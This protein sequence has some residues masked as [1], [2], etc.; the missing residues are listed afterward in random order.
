MG[1]R[2][3]QVAC[4]VVLALLLGGLVWHGLA[5]ADVAIKQNYLAFADDHGGAGMEQAA[6]WL[7]NKAPGQLV[8]ADAGPYFEWLYYP[9]DVL[10]MRA[11]P[12]DL[13]VESADITYTDVPANLYARGVRYL[14]IGQTE[15]G[16]DDEL[17]I[18]GITGEARKQIRQVAS[19][20]NH[21]AYPQP[22][23]LQTVIFEVLPPG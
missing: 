4:L 3:G 9:G 16:V 10:Y 22:H 19:W 5:R 1:L 15:K 11:V 13:P 14:V 2:A 8:A 7:N 6:D 23:D 20:T 21:Y 18:F 12:W 17:K